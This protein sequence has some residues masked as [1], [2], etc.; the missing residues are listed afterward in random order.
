MENNKWENIMSGMIGFGLGI[1]F[2]GI[3][4]ILRI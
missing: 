1:L 4:V 2:G 3:L